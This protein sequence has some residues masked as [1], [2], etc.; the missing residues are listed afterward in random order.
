M[1]A[2]LIFLNGLVISYY[3]DTFFCEYQNNSSE[4]QVGNSMATSMLTVR[5]SRMSN[6]QLQ[7]LAD[8]N[9]SV[10]SSWP[11]PFLTRSI[12]FISRTSGVIY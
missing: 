5:T 6:S 3:Y 9:F 8:K 7:F 10:I 4:V 2:V 11:L 12:F 1:N